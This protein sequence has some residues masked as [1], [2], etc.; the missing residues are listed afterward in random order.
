MNKVKSKISI[1]GLP[2][3]LSD[4]ADFEDITAK[5]ALAIL[6]ET[7]GESDIHILRVKDFALSKWK[8]RLLED[9][10]IFVYEGKKP[11]VAQIKKMLL[12]SHSVEKVKD[13]KLSKVKMKELE[14]LSSKRRKISNQI[15]SLYSKIREIDSN[16]AFI[17]PSSYKGEN[18]EDV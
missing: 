6:E 9:S 4:E 16:M 18:E 13:I 3:V 5:D 15:E 14:D 2:A 1:S 7:F 10:A 12:E 11:S 17:D 8:L